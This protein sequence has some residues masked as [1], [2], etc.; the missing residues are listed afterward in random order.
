LRFFRFISVPSRAN[1][2]RR[3]G[4]GIQLR[5]ELHEQTVVVVAWGDDEKSLLHLIGKV[6]RK[7]EIQS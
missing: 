1:H 3:S 2:W 5:Q 6:R 7:G 4:R